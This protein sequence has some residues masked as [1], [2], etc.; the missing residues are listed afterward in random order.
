[1]EPI[2]HFAL[3]FAVAAL[4]GFRL[5]WALIAGLAGATPD[6]DF[7][8]SVHPS[9][10]HSLLPPLLLAGLSV[11]VL[12]KTEIGSRLLLVALSFG[13]HALLDF[14]HGNYVPILWP[15]S[16]KAYGLSFGLKFHMSAPSITWTFQIVE[17][18]YDYGVPMVSDGMV[19]G[20]NGFTIAVFIV[21]AVLI[22]RLNTE[23]RCA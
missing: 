3:I 7:L 10:T 17:K 23:R 5:R 15:L 20:S 22:A 1:M 2:M 6:L 8:F 19:L 11:I 13:S 21:A 16:D 14:S 4:L 18:A 9:I 12:R